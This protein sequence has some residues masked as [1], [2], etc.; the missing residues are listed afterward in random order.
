[1]EQGETPE[2]AA[3]RELLEEGGATLKKMRGLCYMH[4]F[5]FGQEYWGITY[6]GEIDKLGAPIDSREVT[7]TS[8]FADVPV[9]LPHELKGQA[10]AL[11]RAA[12]EQI[13]SLA[14]DECCIDD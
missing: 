11:H 3:H 5:M 14:N 13:L 9:K 4:C 7:E 2:E 10:T 8:M 1:V 6:L 12:L